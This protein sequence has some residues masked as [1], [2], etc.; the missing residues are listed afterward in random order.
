MFD[1]VLAMESITA[2]ARGSSGWLEEG[3]EAV[4]LRALR[5]EMAFSVSARMAFWDFLVPK[6]R[7]R[8]AREESCCLLDR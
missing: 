7:P 2:A 3:V 4:P 6:E 8:V 1:V 5:G